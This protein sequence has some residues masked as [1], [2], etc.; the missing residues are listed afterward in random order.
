MRD[1]IGFLEERKSMVQSFFMK[2][3][4]GCSTT[5]ER[6]RTV[7]ELEKISILQSFFMESYCR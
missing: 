6:A 3:P 4:A 7:D 2:T 1:G 5:W